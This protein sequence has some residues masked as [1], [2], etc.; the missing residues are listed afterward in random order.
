MAAR[1]R[2]PRAQTAPAA[3]AILEEVEDSK[4]LNIDGGIVIATTILLLTAIVVVWS[5]MDARYPG[6]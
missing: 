2:T 1:K 3:K 4:G 5:L 6:A